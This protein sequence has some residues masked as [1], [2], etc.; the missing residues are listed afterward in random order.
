MNYYVSDLHFG[1]TNWRDG[2]T[3]ETDDLIVE[4]WNK[5]VTNSDTVYILGDIGKEGNAA[6]NEKLIQRLAILKGK[7]K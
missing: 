5:T 1:W 6:D 4:N 7:K 3:L 2:K